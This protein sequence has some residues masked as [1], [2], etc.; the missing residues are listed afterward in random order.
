MVS[1]EHIEAGIPVLMGTEHHEWQVAEIGC[2][3][4]PLFADKS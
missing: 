3:K 1:F 2:F 4:L